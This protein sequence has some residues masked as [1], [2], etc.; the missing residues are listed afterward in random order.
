MCR[1][2]RRQAAATEH[3]LQ[4]LGAEPALE[5]WAT[6]QRRRCRRLTA[7]LA[8][9]LCLLALTSC[10]WATAMARRA[11]VADCHSRHRILNDD[12]PLNSVSY[13][14][15]NLSDSSFSGSGNV[16]GGGSTESGWPARALLKA[17]AAAGLALGGAADASGV[18]TCDSSAPYPPDALSERSASCQPVLQP[19]SCS[20]G[21]AEALQQQARQADVAAASAAAETA[22]VRERLEASIE[23]SALERQHMAVLWGRERSAAERLH[24]ALQV[25]PPMAAPVTDGPA[26]HSRD[27]LDVNSTRCHLLITICHV[28]WS[29]L[30]ELEGNSTLPLT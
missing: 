19:V 14:I 20:A 29:G 15:G 27:V 7:V 12:A 10:G 26:R 4:Q 2:A 25:P 9:A 22:A 18:R 28:I 11:K 30:S 17:R 13:G 8:A 1:L 24:A 6:Q 23:E 3:A 16:S 21:C 5:A